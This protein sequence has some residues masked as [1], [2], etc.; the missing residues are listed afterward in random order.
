MINMF[1]TTHLQTGSQVN[2]DPVSTVQT[3]HLQSVETPY[4]GLEP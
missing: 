2:T 1:N 4:P 3:T